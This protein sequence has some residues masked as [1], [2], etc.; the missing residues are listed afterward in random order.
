MHSTATLTLALR[1]VGVYTANAQSV[2]GEF[3]LADISVPRG[4]YVRMGLGVPNLFAEAGL[5]RLFM[6]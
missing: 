5:V 6:W 2:V 4:V 3:F 1:N